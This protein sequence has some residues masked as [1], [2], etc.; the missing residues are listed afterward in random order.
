MR[1]FSILIRFKIESIT[2]FKHEHVPNEF[3][4]PKQYNNINQEW[5]QY[6][7]LRK[8]IITLIDQT[9]LITQLY[10]TVYIL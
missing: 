3:I 5:L 4:I 10:Y 1:F 7:R 8:T 6:T 9:N 2:A